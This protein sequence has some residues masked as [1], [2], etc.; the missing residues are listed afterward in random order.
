MNKT[1]VV[2]DELNNFVNKFFVD[3]DFSSID[4]FDKESTV[5]MLSKVEEALVN[6]N[7]Q[8]YSNDSAELWFYRELCLRALVVLTQVDFFAETLIEFRFMER[9]LMLLERVMDTFNKKIVEDPEIVKAIQE[10][11]LEEELKKHFPDESTTYRRTSNFI[12]LLEDSELD[13]I[14]EEYEKIPENF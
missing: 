5:K 6:I 3:M 7:N 4:S 10:G 9:A 11:R 14:P 13:A 1:V 12:D 2:S 8:N